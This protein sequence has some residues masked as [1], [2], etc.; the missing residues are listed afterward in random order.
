MHGDGLNITTICCPD[1]GE[2]YTIDSSLAIYKEEPIHTVVQ[3][4]AIPDVPVLARSGDSDHWSSDTRTVIEAEGM[5]KQTVEDI[6]TDRL[7]LTLHDNLRGPS[8]TTH[9]VVLDYW[10]AEKATAYAAKPTSSID[11]PDGTTL[12]YTMSGD[13]GL[14]D[15]LTQR[16]PVRIIVHSAGRGDTTMTLIDESTAQLSSAAFDLPAGCTMVSSKEFNASE[17]PTNPHSDLLNNHPLPPGYGAD[18]SE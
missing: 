15:D 13:S 14:I 12:T 11:R 18:D 6:P 3:L 5:Q 17:H 4:F 1:L 16:M 2:V 10:V 8:D 7:R 9:D